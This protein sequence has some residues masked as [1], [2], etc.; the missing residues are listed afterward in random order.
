MTVEEARAFAEE[1]NASSDEED[2]ALPVA[3]ALG[4]IESHTEHATPLAPA[5]PKLSAKPSQV[6]DGNLNFADA[7]EALEQRQTFA[8]FSTVD[9]EPK[10]PEVQSNSCRWGQQRIDHVNGAMMMFVRGD[11]NSPFSLARTPANESVDLMVRLVEYY[12]Y[13]SFCT[14][15]L[16]RDL[17]IQTPDGY[18]KEMVCQYG[19]VFDPLLSDGSRPFDRVPLDKRNKLKPGWWFRIPKDLAVHRL[20]FDHTCHN[21]G[22]FSDTFFDTVQQMNVRVVYRRFVAASPVFWAAAFARLCLC[23]M[24]NGAF[25]SGNP[26]QWSF[27]TLCKYMWN[28]QSERIGNSS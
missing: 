19:L 25:E 13:R 21:R 7:S 20:G 26:E 15:K 28:W 2:A 3:N 27:L 17:K 10:D 8:I 4:S 6:P 22:C 9:L 23:S 18:V 16:G 14:S 5:R 11:A 1:L 24:N 12:D